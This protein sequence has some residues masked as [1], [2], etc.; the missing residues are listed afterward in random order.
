MLE[1][2]N[3]NLSKRAGHACHMWTTILFSDYMAYYLA[4]AMALFASK[5]TRG[6]QEALAE[7][8]G[9]RDPESPEV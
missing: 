8:R 4:M 7:A 5:G 6:F 1:G 9:S 2:M 3:I